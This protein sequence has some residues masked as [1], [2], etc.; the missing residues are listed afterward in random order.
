MAHG[1]PGSPG[2][3]ARALFRP[4]RCAGPAGWVGGRATESE[5]VAAA[6]AR[7]AAALREPA[8]P[9]P[10]ALPACGEVGEPRAERVGERRDRVDPA[11]VL[12]ERERARPASVVREAHRRPAPRAL[13]GAT[14]EQERHEHV[15]ALL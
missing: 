14:V 8:R 15:V 9:A 5:P 6:R 1:L 4:L 3:A 11:R 10:T 7:C 12:R 13:V 2:W